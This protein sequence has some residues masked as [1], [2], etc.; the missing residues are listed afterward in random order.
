[1][2][3]RN[4]LLATLVYKTV[5]G[6]ILGGGCQDS[7]FIEKLGF[8]V[9]CKCFSLVDVVGQW[10]AHSF[11]KPVGIG[12]VTKSSD[13]VLADRDDIV[14]IPRAVSSACGTSSCWHDF[15]NTLCAKGST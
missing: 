7:A 2:P 4:R 9:F 3:A 12:E 15:I 8:P 1:M 11:G 14:I 13:Y 10:P 6:Y 5:P